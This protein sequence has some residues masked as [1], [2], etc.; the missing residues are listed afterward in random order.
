MKQIKKKKVKKE[1]LKITYISNATLVRAT[2]ASKFQAL[3][4]KLTGKNF[5][6]GEKDDERRYFSGFS[7]V[8]SAR[9]LG[10]MRLIITTLRIIVQQPLRMGICSR[11]AI[12]TL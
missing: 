3:V 12:M 6:V 7:V 1:P 5:Q 11:T 8:G 10:M 2:N 9:L 4:P